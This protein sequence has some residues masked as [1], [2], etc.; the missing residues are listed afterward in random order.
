MKLYKIKFEG[1]GSKKARKEFEDYNYFDDYFIDSKKKS[2][3]I[4]GEN[5]DKIR[6]II[7]ET[8]NRTE[9]CFG[10]ENEDYFIKKLKDKEEDDY[11]R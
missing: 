3:I 6:D 8:E 2:V 11:E 1:E 9:Y 5:K 10:V 7:R 4:K